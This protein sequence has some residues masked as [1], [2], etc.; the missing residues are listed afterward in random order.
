M[1]IRVDPRKNSGEISK[2]FTGETTTY[3]MII[4]KS[5][6]INRECTP[7]RYVKRVCEKMYEPVNPKVIPDIT[8]Q[9]R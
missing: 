2:T 1:K 3:T 6:P 7:V 8:E 4:I 9:D 5:I